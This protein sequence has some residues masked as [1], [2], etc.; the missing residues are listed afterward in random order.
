MWPRL[1]QMCPWRV[2][3]PPSTSGLPEG[4]CAWLC[5]Q[6]S[7]TSRDPA[8]RRPRENPAERSFISDCASAPSGAQMKVTL[9][10]TSLWVAALLCAKTSTKSFGSY[11]EPCC[12][13]WF[14]WAESL[15]QLREWRCKFSSQDPWQ[16]HGQL[17]IRHGKA[18]F[19]RAHLK[20]TPESLRN[21][22][23]LHRLALCLLLSLWQ[24]FT[25]EASQWQ[26]NQT[27]TD[28]SLSIQPP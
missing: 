12:L 22:P 26:S 16:A 7:P 21:T 6:E 18:P 2:E 4:S 13:F 8:S 15:G 23:K 20:Q 3:I 28:R 25:L 5:R 14:N 11:L 27:Q 17:I 19:K 24:K 9:G 1:L 10:T